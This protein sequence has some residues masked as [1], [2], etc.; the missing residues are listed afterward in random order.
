MVGRGIALL[1]LDRGIRRGWLVS[2]TPRPHF[3]VGK[4]SV[5]ILQEAGWTQG[6][7]GRAENLVPIGIRSRAIQPVAQS[8]YRLSYLVHFFLFYN[9]K[10]RLLVS[11][12]IGHHQAKYWQKLQNAGANNI[13]RQYHGI[14][15]TLISFFIINTSYSC[16]IC[17]KFF[18]MITVH[19]ILTNY[20]IC[21]SIFKFLWIFRQMM[22]YSDRN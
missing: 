21:T 10:C 16:V 2:S 20:I 3:T 1:F 7:S 13:T 17:S 19:V 11:L 4:D 9:F 14:T 12:W 15:F 22:A 18:D 6:R 5:P 8:L